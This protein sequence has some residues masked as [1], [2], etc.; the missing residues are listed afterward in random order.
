MRLLAGLGNPGSQYDKTRHNVGF[1]LLDALAKEQGA[2]W[3]EFKGGELAEIRLDG[4]KALLFKPMQFM[5]ESGRPL[6][7]V[8]SYYDIAPEDLCVVTDEVYIKPG[9]ARFR[10]GGGDAGHNGIKSLVTHLSSPEFWRVKVGVGIYEQDPDKR[11]HQAPLDEYVL[12]K[13]TPHDYKQ[14]LAL[15]DILL[16]NLVEWLRSGQGFETKTVHLS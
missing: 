15:I 8:M 5:N 7:Q 12:Q 6:Q 13:L 10:Q 2:T 9:S 4:T 3:K 11:H 14:T 1:V 16:P